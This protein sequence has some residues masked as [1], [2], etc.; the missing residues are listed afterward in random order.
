[1]I[2]G[3][4]IH[5]LLEIVLLAGTRRLQKVLHQLEHGHDVSP[6]TGILLRGREVLGEQQGHRGQQ[7]LGG[8]IEVGVL[9]VVGGVA[10]GIDN[11]LGQDLDVLLRFGMGGQVCRIFS[12][13]IHVSVDQGQH[14]VSVRAGGIT[15]VNDGH[16]IPIIL[17]GDGTVVPCQILR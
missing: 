14:I 16:P 11:G 10:A 1:M 17:L 8:V 9:S 13:Q 4:L 6:F 5:Q 2:L 15:Q 12:G 3:Q 7:A